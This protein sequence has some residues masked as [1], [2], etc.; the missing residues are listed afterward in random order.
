MNVYQ[1]DLD[2]EITDPSDSQV[3]G[4]MTW[5]ATQTR[6]AR[7]LKNPRYVRLEG[8]LKMIGEKLLGI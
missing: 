8:S 2:V 1:A 4:S 5:F 6:K 7:L 3:V